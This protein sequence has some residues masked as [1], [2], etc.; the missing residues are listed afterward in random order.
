MHSLILTI[1]YPYHRKTEVGHKGNPNNV[2]K[3]FK[4]AVSTYTFRH[5]SWNILSM[6]GVDL[7]HF[8]VYIILRK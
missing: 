2:T 5:H 7:F 1:I 8:G 6:S 4:P 3:K